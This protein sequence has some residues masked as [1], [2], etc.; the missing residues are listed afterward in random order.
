MKCQNKVCRWLRKHLGIRETTRHADELKKT[1]MDAKDKDI[2]A[3]KTVNRRFGSMI[4]AGR[5]DFRIHEI[6]RIRSGN[7]NG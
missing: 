3:I 5:I 7:G 4:N 6:E 1:I 2:D